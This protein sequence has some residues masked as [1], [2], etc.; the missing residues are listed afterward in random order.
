MYKAPKLEL[1]LQV[2]YLLVDGRIGSVEA[3]RWEFSHR[4][5]NIRLSHRQD[6]SRV[7]LTYNV[8]LGY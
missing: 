8:L 2:N 6:A 4:Q 7:S 3:E 1:I 5:L